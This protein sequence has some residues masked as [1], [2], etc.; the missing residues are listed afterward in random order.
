M[1][2]V[3]TLGALAL[4]FCCLSQAG[5]RSYSSVGE[6][7]KLLQHHPRLREEYLYFVAENPGV[8]M[9]KAHVRYITVVDESS[10][11][12]QYSCELNTELVLTSGQVFTDQ[13]EVDRH[14]E[15]LF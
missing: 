5:Q 14:C 13:V 10:G 3:L 2:S 11:D 7:R 1:K 6:I 4:G 9:A 12:R 8:R 15:H